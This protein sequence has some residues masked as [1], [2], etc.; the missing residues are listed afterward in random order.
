[1]N[2]ETS[3]L[4]QQLAS[5]LGTTTE[6]L[7]GVLLKQ[8]PIDATIQLIQTCI[9]LL[10][11]FVLYKIHLQLLKP[12]KSGRNNAY[13]DSDAYGFIMMA[14]FIVL[15][16]ILVILFCSIGDIVSGYFNPEYWALDKIIGEVK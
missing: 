9:C 11:F 10:G 7:W 13:D 5:K 12:N 8:A 3:K 14:S 4:L 15:C 6:Y 2:E 1:M 16:C